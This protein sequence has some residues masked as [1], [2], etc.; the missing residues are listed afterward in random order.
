[1]TRTTPPRPFD[2]TAPFPELAPLARTTVRLHPRAG[3]PTAADSS[4]GGPLLWPADE[5]W[6]VCPDHGEPWQRGRV[7]EEVHR[8]RDILAQAW[9]RPR[10]VGVGEG[11]ALTAPGTGPARAENVP[12]LPDGLGP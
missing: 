10:P 5:P 2:V 6:P 1:M 12:P 11:Q 9:S 4:V 3:S 7:P 8:R